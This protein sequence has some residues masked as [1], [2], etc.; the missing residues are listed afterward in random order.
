MILLKALNESLNMIEDKKEKDWYVYLLECMDGSYYCGVTNDIDS[1]MN[2]HAIGKGSRYVYSKGFKELLRVQKC[3]N[4]SEACKCEY[5]IKQ[6]SRN[7][8]LDWFRKES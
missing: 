6:L 8:K 5:Q 4:K 1:R 3:D 2:A 7:E